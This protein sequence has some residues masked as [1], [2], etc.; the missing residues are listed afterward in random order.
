[1]MTRANLH[2]PDPKLDLVL[3]RI[4]DVP[5]ELV[6]LAW[7]TPEHVMKWFTPA[8]WMTV[9][10]EIDLRPGGIFRT[11]MRSPEGREFP[12]VGCYLEVVEN[13]KLVWTVAL[14]PG[15]RPSNASSEVPSFTAVISLEP[16]GNGTKYTA[17][18]MHKDEAD[19][20]KHEEMGF[21]VG[22]GQ[23]LDQLVAIA[24]KM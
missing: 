9:Q 14:A 24:K 16:H 17:L 6:W 15:Y 8:P 12:H 10:C 7:T 13:Q 20:K 23:A 11:V 2:Q 22:W 4:V 21:H 3:E 1:M 19:R 5:R 18:A